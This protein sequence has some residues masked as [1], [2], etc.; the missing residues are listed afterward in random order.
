VSNRLY[1]ATTKV[2]VTKVVSLSNK[3]GYAVTISRKGVPMA[4]QFLP[5][6]D[7]TKCIGCGLCV[8]ICPNHVLGIVDNCPQIINPNA[9]DYTAACQEICPAGAITL[10]FEIVFTT[11]FPKPNYFL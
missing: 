6:I 8:K 5:G 11:D 7:E 10:L 2:N 4:E 1:A 9:C 3:I